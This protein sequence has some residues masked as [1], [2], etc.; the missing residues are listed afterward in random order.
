MKELDGLNDEFI[1]WRNAQSDA[2]FTL[3]KIYT[4]ALRNPKDGSPGQYTLDARYDLSQFEMFND[5]V[6]L[7]KYIARL[8]LIHCHKETG[9]PYENWIIE[10]SPV[11]E[12][13]QVPSHLYLDA[14]R[15]RNWLL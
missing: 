11:M 4:K 12:K 14:A 15:D 1:A 2:Q 3:F 6:G 5:K 7:L 8:Y 10:F 9:V 13:Y